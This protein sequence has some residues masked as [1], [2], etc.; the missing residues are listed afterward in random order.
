MMD[1]YSLLRFAHVLCA[2]YWVG[3]SLGVVILTVALR[4]RNYS[5]EFRH[6]L[7]RLSLDVDIPPRIA[8]V[9]ITPFGLHLAGMTGL[10][11]IS[12]P[13]L[14][15]AWVCV[16]IWLGGEYITHGRETEPFAIKIYITIGV[17]MAGACLSLLGLGI[18]ALMNDWP[19]R[20]GW[21]AMKALLLGLVFLVSISMSR[22]YAPL[23]NVVERLKNEGSTEEIET[24][25]SFYLN[26]GMAGSISLI[27]LW[28]TIIYMAVNRPF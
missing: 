17:I 21:L 27:F 18:Y 16:V 28:F 8:M 11:A 6:M 26:R 12:T 5:P 14:V 22:Y 13:V 24:A 3:G 1:G 9:V 23:T 15:L 25:L 7:V 20:Q 19:F 2:I 10:L 4:N